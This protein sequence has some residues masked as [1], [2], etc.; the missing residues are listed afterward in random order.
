MTIPKEEF[1]IT[2]R[3]LPAKPLKSS[4]K[5]SYL[6]SCLACSLSWRFGIIAGAIC[7]FLVLIINSALTGWA[8]STHKIQGGQGTVFEGSC[9]TSK[10]LNV[11]IH[12][13][14][15][16]F[17]T[18]LLGAS[19]YC[20]QEINKAHANM[21]WL[22]IGVP[23]YRNLTKISRKRS[24]LWPVQYL[25]LL[26]V[27]CLHRSYN[28]A[29]YSSVAANKYYG[30]I[31]RERLLDSKESL[32]NPTADTLF[33]NAKAGHLEKL[34]R[35]ECIEAYAQS[36]QASH[37]SLF[38][39]INE[40]W[41]KHPSTQTPYPPNVGDFIDSIRL[42]VQV[43]CDMSGWVCE[44][45]VSASDITCN[46]CNRQEMANLKSQ[47]TWPV[48]GY[49]IDHCLSERTE[50]K[51]KIHFSV[52]IAVLVIIMNTVKVIIFT[53]IAWKIREAPLMNIGDAIVSFIKEPDPTTEGM[54]LMSRDDFEH[55]KEVQRDGTKLLARSDGYQSFC[56]KLTDFRSYLLIP[57][58]VV[59]GAALI[60]CLFFFLY[61]LGNVR[62]FGFT[63]G[64][65]AADPSSLTAGTGG[66]IGNTLIANISQTIF[67]FIY[68]TY[69]T[70]LT[71]LLLAKEWNQYAYH[72]KG[73]RVSSKPKGA[74]RSTY[75][76]QLPYRYGVPFLVVS[77]T[78]HWLISQTI[79]LVS[80]E[81]YQ[82]NGAPSLNTVRNQTA[83]YTYG[84]D[85]VPELDI[86]TSGFSVAGLLAV[87]ALAF[88][89]LF[90][91]IFLG[92][93]SFRPGIPVAG[94]CSAAIS[95]A[96]H[97]VEAEPADAIERRL[98][99][100]MV[101]EPSNGR[102]VGHCG[103]S[104]LE[105]RQPVAHQVYAGLSQR[106][107]FPAWQSNIEATTTGT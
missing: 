14:I 65:G 76:L 94:S 98:K 8:I 74:Q 63:F 1:V 91:L 33:R 96:C 54:C 26:V 43:G 53:S 78:F 100:G 67:S 83:V 71:S 56:C 86:L 77:G 84:V 9:S 31:I 19:N 15:N 24:V 104:S 20:I 61:G 81:A 23:S 38:L 11:V 27:N 69:N 28:S 87:T 21:T 40:T 99:W 5:R 7:S 59:Y 52:H 50:E 51:C 79:F 57:D 95:A 55:E 103:F 3:L 41:A 22:D 102:G 46:R 35:I 64:F 68:V 89:A 39:V 34:T 2:D 42:T 58:S 62:T 101:R 49:L 17:G 18:V 4:R 29:L 48:R 47:N 32:P 16:I 66:I 72:R 6:R 97:C 13:M 88:A 25:D 106:R 90:A 92:R 30:F 75:F 82:S 10:R 44:T 60:V 93:R 85:R 45:N 70:I 107:K 37:G 73:L 36:F 80:V 105:V 12:L